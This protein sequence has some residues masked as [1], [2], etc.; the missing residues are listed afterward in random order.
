MSLIIRGAGCILIVVGILM[1]KL[2]LKSASSLDLWQVKYSFAGIVVGML[3]F[4][5]VFSVVTGTVLAL[6]GKAF[7]E[8]VRGFKK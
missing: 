2:S 4:L 5:G 8:W 3:Y 1:L 7:V 6:W